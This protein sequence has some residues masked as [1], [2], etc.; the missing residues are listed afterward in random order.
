MPQ[1]CPAYMR[2]Q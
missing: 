2:I 1:V